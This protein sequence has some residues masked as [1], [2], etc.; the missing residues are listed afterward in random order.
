MSDA[1]KEQNLGNYVN[2]KLQN[3]Y[4]AEIATE[5]YDYVVFSSTYAVIPNVA[6]MVKHSTKFINKSGKVIVMTTLFDYFNPLMQLF[7]PK[8]KYFLAVDFGR[9]VTR[10]M[11]RSELEEKGLEITKFEPIHTT[12]F[13]SITYLLHV[14]PKSLQQK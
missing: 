6:D 7:K 8:I 2:C 5:G 13:G 9:F 12:W 3:V 1:I 14:K 11:I 4:E 10:S